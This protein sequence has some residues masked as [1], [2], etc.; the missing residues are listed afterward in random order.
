MQT[1]THADAAIA[2]KSKAF[3]DHLHASQAFAA[4]EGTPDFQDFDRNTHFITA[5]CEDA[6]ENGLHG[7]SSSNGLVRVLQSDGLHYRDYEVLGDEPG[8]IKPICKTCTLA[9]YRAGISDIFEHITELKT[10]TDATT[11]SYYL[12]LLAKESAALISV[13]CPTATQEDVAN[14]STAY[15]RALAA[16]G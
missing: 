14:A 11:R 5:E 2:K 3:S 4:L 9:E 1:K 7:F 8:P 6:S 16:I 13:V 10:A 12:G 15:V